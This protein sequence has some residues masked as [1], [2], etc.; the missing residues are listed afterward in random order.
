MMYVHAA[1]QDNGI[2]LAAQV[3]YLGLRPQRDVLLATTAR[4]S[5]GDREMRLMYGAADALVMTARREGWGLPVT[6]AM[7]CGL[8]VVAPDYGPFHA[9][10]DEGRGTLVPT[11]GLAWTAGDNRGPGWVSDPG[12]TA[13][14][15]EGLMLTRGTDELVERCMSSMAWARTNSLASMG[16]T[17]VQV[18]SH[19]G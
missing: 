19:E 12:R 4:L 3:R 7:L 11:L 13:D 14:A 9:Q 16:A 10:L 1:A 15:L 6:E 8:P 2:D 18:V 17:M 5:W